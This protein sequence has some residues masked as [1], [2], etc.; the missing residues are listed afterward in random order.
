MTMQLLHVHERLPGAFG[1]LAHLVGHA[2]LL[3]F[4]SAA[5]VAAVLVA[6]AGVSVHALHLLLACRLTPALLQPPSRL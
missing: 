4:C 6:A 1:L 2:I 3:F 5:A